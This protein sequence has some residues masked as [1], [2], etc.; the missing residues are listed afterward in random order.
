MARQLGEDVDPDDVIFGVVR[1]LSKDDGE[2]VVLLQWLALW[3]A[4]ED[5]FGQLNQRESFAVVY[6]L[7]P[8]MRPSF[9]EML[10]SSGRT[11]LLG[12]MRPI[13][14]ALIVLAGPEGREL[15]DAM[16]KRASDMPVKKNR[17]ISDDG[18]LRARL[19][20]TEAERD[21]IDAQL[22]DRRLSPDARAYLEWVRARTR[23]NRQKHS[24]RPRGR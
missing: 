9:D 15:L 21:E 2:T 16:A 5:R 4:L 10:R 24:C 14:V 13:D 1:Q 12:D 18:T 20:R 8:A 23:T 3:H 11:L 22:F 17:A 7:F 6:G 19:A